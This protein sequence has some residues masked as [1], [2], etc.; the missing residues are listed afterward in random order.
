MLGI[1]AG[2]QPYEFERFGVD[3]K[4]NLEMTGRFS[5]APGSR[6]NPFRNP[7]ARSPGASRPWKLNEEQT[8]PFADVKHLETSFVYAAPMYDDFFDLT[9]SRGNGHHCVE[10]GRAFP[11]AE[12]LDPHRSSLAR[13]SRR[14]HACCWLPALCLLM[15]LGFATRAG[16]PSPILHEL[17]KTVTINRGSVHRAPSSA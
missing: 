13:S 9:T 4:A 10:R 1:G 12:T 11:P 2:Y 15:S 5:T 6:H 3:I 17:V 8:V 16:Y 7:D 14:T